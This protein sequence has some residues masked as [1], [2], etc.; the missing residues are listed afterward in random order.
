MYSYLDCISGRTI[1]AHVKCKSDASNELHIIYCR[2][3]KTIN[4]APEL[5]HFQTTF[6]RYITYWIQRPQHSHTK[7]KWKPNIFLPVQKWAHCRCVAATIS[8]WQV[9]FHPHYEVSCPHVNKAEVLVSKT[10]HPR[11]TWATL[12]GHIM[13]HIFDPLN[14]NTCW[15]T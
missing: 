11:T 15:A 13:R 3:E 10:Y 2:G 6:C 7:A 1:H 5:E 14:I 12:S 4:I 9:N 8:T